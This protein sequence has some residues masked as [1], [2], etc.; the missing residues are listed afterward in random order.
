[1]PENIIGWVWWVISAVVVGLG[2]NLL[3]NYLHPRLE[4][5]WL[6]RRKV[7][8][9]K[10]LARD[11][12]LQR[13]VEILVDQPA[14]VA[15]L[16]QDLILLRLRALQNIGVVLGM[17]LLCLGTQQ[18][19]LV[20]PSEGWEPSLVTRVA[21]DMGV[22]NTGLLSLGPLVALW[23]AAIYGLFLATIISRQSVRVSLCIRLAEELAASRGDPGMEIGKESRLW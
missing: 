9:K 7:Q 20:F 15:A 22:T 5:R 3:A 8:D 23:L 17:G 19:V 14:R 12:E 13:Q 6:A 16:K 10:R 21:V 2:L 4:R 1:M 18:G 11:R